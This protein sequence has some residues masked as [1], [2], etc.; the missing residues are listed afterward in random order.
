VLF[1]HE[2]HEVVG[3][4]EDEFEAALR[5][6]WRP[7]VARDGDAALL[8]FLHHA[9]GTGPSYRVVTITAVRNGAAWQRLIERVDGGDL[10]ELA[11]R[12]DGLRHDVRAKVL[13]PLPWSPLQSV[14]LPPPAAPAALHEPTLFM[15]DT[16]WPHEGRLEEYVARSGSHYAK[17]MADADAGERA[18]LRIQAGFRTAYGAGRRREIV[19]WQKLVR[20]RGLRPLIAMEVPPE[21][22]APGTWMHDAL[23]LRD[24]W[25][26]R[27]LRSA[28]WSPLY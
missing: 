6:G 25:E 4:R 13:V 16:V 23:E 26:S 1:V 7:A 3:S 10:A 14:A 22:K 15:E 21:Y 19:L 9:H 28:R 18:L 17:E 2:L 8:Y 12:I 5:D 20:P 24:R 27:L 11:A